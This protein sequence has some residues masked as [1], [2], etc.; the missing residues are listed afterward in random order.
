MP[1]DLTQPLS[2]ESAAGDAAV[3]LDELQPNIVKAHTREFLTVLFLKF[4]DPAGG[5]ALLKSLSQPP[6]GAPLLKAA[7]THLMEVKAFKA[8][9]TKGTPYVG[10]GITRHGS[11]ALQV[12]DPTIPQDGSFLAGMKNAALNDP[13]PANWDPHFRDVIDAVI[14]VG[15]QMSGPRNRVLAAVHQ[16]DRQQAEQGCRP[17][18]HGLQCKHRAAVR[19]CARDMGKQ[20]GLSPGAR[21]RRQPRSRPGDRPEPQPAPRYRLSGAM[22]RLDDDHHDRTAA[23][24]DHEGRRILLHAVAG[25]LSQPPLA[26]RFPFT[27]RT[28]LTPVPVAGVS[29]KSETE[30]VFAPDVPG[31]QAFQPL[32]SPHANEAHIIC[33]DGLPFSPGRDTF[34]GETIGGYA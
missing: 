10:V 34:P 24:S 4:T 8:N 21:R 33:R 29:R 17:A 23:G 7:R 11:T 9:G 19:I 1:F 20:S 25:L 31:A 27:H 3:M 14:L 30:C 22:G 2:W 13:A 15:D 16:P 6:A 18:V 12:P 5:R 26:G 28:L 32:Y